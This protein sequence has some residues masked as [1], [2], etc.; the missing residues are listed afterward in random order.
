MVCRL[1]IDEVGNDDV[2]SP[3]E[4]YLS[5]TAIYCKLKAHETK[6]TPLIETLKT[7]FFGHNPPEK[8][9]VLHRKELVRKEAPFDALRSPEL[10]DEWEAEILQMLSNLPYLVI[11][12]MIDKH[13]HKERYKV[14]RFNP[15][16]YCMTAIVER[17]V[18][19]LKRNGE[20]GDVVVEARHKKVDKALKKAFAHIWENGTANVS[21]NDVQTR[22]TSKA[23]KFATK[24]ENVAGLQLVEL[25]AHS[26]HHGTKAQY[27]G[28]E[29][30]ASFGKR[31]YE[32]L[33]QSKY[34]RNPKNGRISGW[35]QKWLP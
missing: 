24:K 2:D 26:S 13:E 21:A 34:C 33:L 18:T 8:L 32:I 28:V 22:L 9:I 17:Y 27:T 1:F 16:H 4:R 3:A 31:I 12:V 15:Y 30:K 10:N 29:A 20:S 14:W 11:T 6:V 35:G 19:W 5:L 23:L 25:L 7:K